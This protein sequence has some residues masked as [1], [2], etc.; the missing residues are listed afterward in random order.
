M[1][2]TDKTD[3][4]Q[5]VS[6]RAFGEFTKP[7]RFLSNTLNGFSEPLHTQ[8]FLKWGFAPYPNFILKNKIKR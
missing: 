8:R 2:N 3:F 1:W 5:E 7:L 6:F 4:G